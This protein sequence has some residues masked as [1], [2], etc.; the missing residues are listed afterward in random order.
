ML[1]INWEA[2]INT[3]RSARN[4]QMIEID[5]YKI[6]ELISFSENIE[7]PFSHTVECRFFKAD[8]TKKLY[9]SM[10]SPPD[11]LAYLSETDILSISKTGFI[12]ELMILLAQSLGISTC[13]Y[14]HY[15]LEELERLMPHLEK[16][17]YLETSNMGFGYSKGEVEGRR[18][19]CITP[20]GYHNEKGLRIVD[21]MTEKFI[22]FKRKPIED[23]L[24]TK[25][26]I[27]KISDTIQ[28][29]MNLARLAPSAANSQH[30]RFNV[31]E[32]NSKITIAMPI[33][34][35]HMKW[36][37]PNVDIGICACHLWLGLKIKNKEPKVTV[38][39]DNG[40]ALWTF[41][42]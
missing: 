14:G 37:H 21:R 20:L 15:K 22:S 26:S 9:F 23:L 25:E 39:E 3:R 28:Y 16:K 33:G 42:I 31:T 7:V 38:I 4:Y 40:R 10:Q 19:I 13:W 34:Y 11:N 30:W 18:A 2:A 6:Q 32:D 29:A 5:K 1:N 17:S 27:D 41:E 24:I 35:K 8:P 12:G 36:E